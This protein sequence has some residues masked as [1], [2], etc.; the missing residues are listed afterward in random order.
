M[1]L[2]IVCA[3]ILMLLLHVIS[4]PQNPMNYFLLLVLIWGIYI[5]RFYVFP[6][7]TNNKDK[8]CK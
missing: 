3:I 4:I 5:I 7:Q 2:L 1:I 8:K 6:K